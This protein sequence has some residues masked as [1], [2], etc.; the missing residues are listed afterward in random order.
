M[1]PPGGE[2]TRFSAASLAT[3]GG[4]P[5]TFPA[6]PNSPLPPPPNPNIPL[7]HRRLPWR[8]RP[9]SPPTSTS[10]TRS[11][12]ISPPPSPAPPPPR[13]ISKAS[14]L[15]LLL[16][17]FDGFA[18]NVPLTRE[19]RAGVEEQS[20]E[21]GRGRPPGEG[22]ERAHFSGSAISGGQRELAPLLPRGRALPRR[23]HRVTKDD[24]PIV[25]HDD[26]ILTQEN[27]MTS[28][29]LVTDLSLEEFL[30]YGL[31]KDSSKASP[32]EIAI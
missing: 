15:L 14:F 18:H 9:C 10:S 24:C 6:L 31:Q 4:I 1:I 19:S 27:G 29:K 17:L 26:S 28:E 7:L 21:A 30:S 20:G 2:E 13:S 32:A 23:L 5:G 25:F 12:T 22:N 3:R 8:S 16:F 11:R